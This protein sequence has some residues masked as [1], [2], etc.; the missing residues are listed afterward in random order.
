MSKDPIGIN[1][2]LNTIYVRNTMQKV[3]PYGLNDWGA[4]ASLGGPAVNQ[5]FLVINIMVKINVIRKH[6]I[7][8]LVF[9]MQNKIYK[10]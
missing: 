1:G 5:K 2:G 7:L 9:I 3:D 10:S 8:H 4:L 6:I